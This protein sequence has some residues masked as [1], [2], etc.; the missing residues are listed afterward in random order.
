[1][2]YDDR[3]RLC[4]FV[5]VSGVEYTLQFDEVS[6]T[7]GKKASIHEI[8]DTDDADTQDQG[9]KIRRLPMQ[10]YI[11]G[12]D[13]DIEADNFFDALHEKDTTESHAEL[14]HPR[15]GNFNVMVMEVTQKEKFVEGLGRA[16]FDIS[17]VKI[18]ATEYP[19]SLGETSDELKAKKITLDD[20]I[21]G[22]YAAG[23]RLRTLAEKNVITQTLNTMNETA[24]EV[25]GAVAEVEE[26]VNDSFN[27]ILGAINNNLDTLLGT[28]LILAGSYTNLYNQI[29]SVPGNIRDKINGYKTM[30]DL[31]FA[32]SVPQANNEGRNTVNLQQLLG[33]AAVSSLMESVLFQ[34]YQTRD[35]VLFVIT[36]VET[37]NDLLVEKLDDQ[38]TFFENQN[39]GDSFATAQDVLNLVFNMRE[40]SINYLLQQSF[41]LAVKKTFTTTKEYTPLDLNFELYE[42]IDK[43]DFFLETN[44]IGSN[45]FFNIPIGREIIVYE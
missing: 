23:Q 39:I 22:V 8:P 38:E 11:S 42:D 25:L 6:R 4:R 35:E 30:F 14:K 29:I 20:I 44:N 21:A 12:Q 34:D 40:L 2:S 32:E 41:Q 37:I 33:V 28:P 7:G 19:L 43:L 24:N 45:E 36:E 5:S 9:N 10:L 16:V 3:L 18:S 17:F 13:Y 31:I 26:A 1:M 27:T 15:W